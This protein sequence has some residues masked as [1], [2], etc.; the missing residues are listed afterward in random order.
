MAITGAEDGSVRISSIGQS[1]QNRVLPHLTGVWVVAFRVCARKCARARVCVQALV[2]G[3]L[4]CCDTQ[5]TGEAPPCIWPVNEM[6][7][8]KS[9]RSTKQTNLPLLRTSQDYLFVCA[10][11]LQSL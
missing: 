1:S 10:A 7:Q 6:S 4:V 11:G 2:L 5:E 9:C 8:P 3:C